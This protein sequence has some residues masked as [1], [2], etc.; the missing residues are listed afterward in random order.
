LWRVFLEVPL[1]DIAKIDAPLVIETLKRWKK[2]K[3]QELKEMDFIIH[4]ALRT[5]V[6]QGDEDA[7]SMLGYGKTP[8]IEVKDV[9]LHT[10]SVRVGEALEFEVEIVALDDAMLMVDYILHFQT[11]AGK[12]SPKV[13][14]LKKFKLA[15]GESIV[16]KKKH[17][18]RANMTTRTLY[19][20]EHLLEV[21]IN[22]SIVYR[23]TFELKE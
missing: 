4:H 23:E 8:P 9:R 17:P 2:S 12:L 19:A 15:E 5:L 18:F 14:K 16:L 11:K 7:L 1:N 3:K 6:K 20:G 22:G 13:H 10:P 21:Q